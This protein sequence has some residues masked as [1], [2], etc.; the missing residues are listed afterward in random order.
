MNNPN[1]MRIILIHC[2]VERFKNIPLYE[3][4]LYFSIMLRKMP[5]R[6]K[7][8]D[9]SMDLKRVNLIKNKAS[10]M[11]KSAIASTN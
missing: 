7:Y 11:I 5:Y 3:S 8:I 2:D 10:E 9:N 4:Y 1:T 6:I